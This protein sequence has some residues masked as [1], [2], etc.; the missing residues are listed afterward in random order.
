MKRVGDY[1]LESG[2]SKISTPESRQHS[3]A[4]GGARAR[5]TE[6]REVQ[7]REVILFFLLSSCLLVVEKVVRREGA[8][9]ELKGG[10]RMRK[11]V[12]D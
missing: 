8:V 6:G 2:V 12:F 10:L 7:R 4:G 5:Q 9:V 1:E 3:R 11:D